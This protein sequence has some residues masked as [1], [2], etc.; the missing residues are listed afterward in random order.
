[1]MISNWHYRPKDNILL[2]KNKLSLHFS[3][4]DGSE[5]VMKCAQILA[6]LMHNIEI[7]V[8]MR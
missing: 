4:N 3:L 1:M 7:P 2:G 6:Y 5:K 8:V